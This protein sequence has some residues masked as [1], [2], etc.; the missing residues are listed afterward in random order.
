MDATQCAR[1]GVLSSFDV[2]TVIALLYF[3]SLTNLA[4]TAFLRSLASPWCVGLSRLASSQTDQR[5]E[6]TVP[7]YDPP[8]YS[9]LPDTDDVSK[10]TVQQSHGLSYLAAF[11]LGSF[12][13]ALLLYTDFLLAKCLQH[14]RYCP[15]S[16]PDAPLYPG[17]GVLWFVYVCL[18]LYAC[19][20]YF[21]WIV[22]AMKVI[23]MEP[24]R[25]V[26]L[27]IIGFI[28]IGLVMAPFILIYTIPINAF[29]AYRNQ[30]SRG[31]NGAERAEG[32]DPELL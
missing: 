29:K 3:G 28:V 9:L 18:L 1:A 10:E 21:A 32:Q 27:D 5:T 11:I 26:P 17:L 31:L 25:R 22:L 13:A 2:V 6:Q 16:N 14:L 24:F 20:G 12:L 7:S 30:R 23:G 8:P 4:L 19:S 15:V